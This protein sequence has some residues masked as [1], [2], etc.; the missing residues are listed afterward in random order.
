MFNWFTGI[1]QRQPR[2]RY[3]DI[4]VVNN[5]FTRDGQPSDYGISAGKDCRVLTENNHFIDIATPIYTSHQ[6]GS[7]ANELR[8]RQ[9]L[10]EHERE[11]HGLRNGVRA[12]LRVRGQVGPCRAGRGAGDGGR[13]GHARESWRGRLAALARSKPSSS[14]VWFRALAKVAGASPRSGRETFSKALP[15]SVLG[16]PRVGSLLETKPWTRGIPE[17]KAGLSPSDFARLSLPL[18]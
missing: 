8:G 15:R 2:C 13:W 4:H 10:R 18:G 6:S 3:G 9:H 5:L 14:F 1:A 16:P 7:S 11:H 17:W 12:T